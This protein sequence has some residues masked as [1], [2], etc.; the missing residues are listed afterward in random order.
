MK[1][2]EARK[3]R[4]RAAQRA[5]RTIRAWDQRRPGA[6]TIQTP[7][8]AVVLERVQCRTDASGLTY[9]DVTLG[10]EVAGG[11]VHF[12]V[13]NPPTLVR[14]PEGDVVAHGERWREDPLAALAEAIGSNGG[15]QAAR[16]RRYGR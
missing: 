11:D 5:G 13:V 14:D 3:V 12:R 1:D 2:Q 16:K 9:L 4:E 7:H 10:G 8:G 6:E 15:A